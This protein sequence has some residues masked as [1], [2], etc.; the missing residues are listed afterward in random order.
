M[1]NTNSIPH[2]RHFENMLNWL[3]EI[4]TVF[5]MQ[6][7]LPLELEQIVQTYLDSGQYQN[8]AEVLMAGLQLLQH[9]KTSSEMSFGILD[10][11]SQFLPLTESEMIQE[12][13]KVLENYQNNGIPQSEVEIWANNLGKH[14]K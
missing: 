1:I 2:S 6:I 7:T 3:C 12:S 8:P 10:R 14:P 13:L 11:Q 5:L 9:N 4:H